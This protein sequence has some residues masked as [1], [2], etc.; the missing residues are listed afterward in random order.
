MVKM[1]IRKYKDLILYGIF[2]VLTTIANIATY[3]VMAHPLGLP[4]ML[5]TIIAW[6]VAVLFA[7]VTNR[8]W[9]FH[10]EAHTKDEVVRELGSFFAC[11]LVTG[12]VDWLC[13]LIFVTVLQ[14]N[15]VAIK[16]IANVVV[17]VL[18]YIASKLIIF[19][20]KSR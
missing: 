4:T 19:K 20:H 8:K 1:L 7:Y 2:G 9:V 5:S 18:N 17:I 6:I 14:F 3:W 10:S 13:M 16:A 15:D 12:V 11:R